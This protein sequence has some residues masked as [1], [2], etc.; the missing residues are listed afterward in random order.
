MQWLLHV[1][2]WAMG[3]GDGSW[4]SARTAMYIMRVVLRIINQNAR[5]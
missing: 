4:V 1:A 5:Q 3:S 2:A